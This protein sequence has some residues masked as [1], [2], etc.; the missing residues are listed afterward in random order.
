MSTLRDRIEELIKAKHLT[1][2]AFARSIGVA[3]SNFSKM[4]LGDQTITEKTLFK[5]VEAFNDVSFEW[6]RDGQGEMFKKERT[7][8]KNPAPSAP[9][10]PGM[11]DL[12]ELV[13]SQKKQIEDLIKNNQELTESN[14]KLVFRNSRLSDQLEE[15]KKQSTETPGIPAA[16]VV[17]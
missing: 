9:E 7:H 4:M 3:S 14:K 13:I 12:W 6:L 15:N 1:P 10:V 17:S 5:I 8:V 16:S 2:T 11:A